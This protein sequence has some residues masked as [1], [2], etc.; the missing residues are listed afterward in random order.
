M[1]TTKTFAIAGVS[2]RNGETKI[3]FAND[4]MRVKILA[5]GGFT[6]IEL[7][8]LPREMTKGE[9]AVYMTETGF[10]KDNPATLAAIAYIAKK[11]PAAKSAPV[12][13]KATPQVAALKGVTPLGIKENEDAPF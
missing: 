9:I 11:N 6:D 3:R 4:M 5:K 12:K 2:T 7:I 8:E 10:G 13:T 1:S